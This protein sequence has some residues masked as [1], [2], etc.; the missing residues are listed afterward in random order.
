MPKT[1]EPLATQTLGSA[2]ASVTFNSISGAYTDLVL[3]VAGTCSSNSY[4]GLRFNGDTASNYS[5]TEL[6]GYSGGAYSARNPA[7]VYA[8]VGSIL[9][10]QS[11]IL[12]NIFNYSNATTFKTF[13]VKTSATNDIVKQS[14]GLWKATAQAITSIEVSTA[15]GGNFTIGTTFSLYGIKAA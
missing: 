7:N 5:N 13:L 11:N 14:V 6:G 9:T 8:Y 12:T 4:F 15:G 2:Q 10:T 1:Y 3:V